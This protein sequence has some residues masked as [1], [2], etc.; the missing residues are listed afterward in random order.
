MDEVVGLTQH[1]RSFLHSHVLLPLAAE[2]QSLPYPAKCVYFVQEYVLDRLIR[3]IFLITEANLRFKMCSYSFKERYKKHRGG[4]RTMQL[5]KR[6]GG[7][8]GEKQIPVRLT[9]VV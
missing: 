5:R 3:P 9:D 1:Q 6:S 8:N 2:V 4:L 7:K